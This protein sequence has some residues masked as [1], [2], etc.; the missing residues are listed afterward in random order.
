MVA[1]FDRLPSPF[2]SCDLGALPPSGWSEL[3]L[4][5]LL[6]FRLGEKVSDCI[7]VVAIEDLDV[8]EDLRI[9]SRMAESARTRLVKRAV[10][11]SVPEKDQSGTKMI[12][13][14][15]YLLSVTDPTFA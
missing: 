4:F 3:S 15:V 13:A 11:D 2:I 7:T 14:G 8:M 12:A 10:E 5:R 6:V 9:R 1:S